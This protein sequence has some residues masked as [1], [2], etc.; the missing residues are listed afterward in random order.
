MCRAGA[1]QSPAYATVEGDVDMAFQMFWRA[2]GPLRDAGKLECGPS[3]SRTSST[4]L[5][6]SGGFVRVRFGFLTF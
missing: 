5:N 1:E 2:T 6:V 3:N 4:S